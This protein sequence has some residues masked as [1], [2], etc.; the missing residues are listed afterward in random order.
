MNFKHSKESEDLKGFEKKFYNAIVELAT[1]LCE[2]T[3]I[4]PNEVMMD[5]KEEVDNALEVR[6]VLDNKDSEVSNSHL[7]SYAYVLCEHFP[8]FFTPAHYRPYMTI[9][10]SLNEEN[11]VMMVG[12]Y[13][14]GV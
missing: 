13:A 9:E 10:P 2:S 8:A 6:V 3:D 14:G 4:K 1:I 12:I 11:N 7:L 5:Y